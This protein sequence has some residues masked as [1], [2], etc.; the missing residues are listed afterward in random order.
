MPYKIVLRDVDTSGLEDLLILDDRV[1]QM[2]H[3]KE[4]VEVILHLHRLRTQSKQ[5]SKDLPTRSGDTLS[6]F[7]KWK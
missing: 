4:E 7:S 6:A 3:V 1:S 2:I 5:R